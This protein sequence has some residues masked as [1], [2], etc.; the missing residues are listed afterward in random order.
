M[1]KVKYYVIASA[2][3]LAGIFAAYGD[4]SN[5]TRAIANV[6]V[7]EG[8]YSNDAGDP[9]GP[10]KYGITIWDVRKYLKPNATAADVKRLTREEAETIYREHYAKPIG[11][12]AMPKGLDYTVLDYSVNAGIG[13]AI[14]D[15]TKCKAMHKATIDLIKCVNAKR[16]AFQMGLPSR[17]DKFKKGWRRRIVSVEKISLNMAGVDKAIIGDVPA[18]A[19]RG[20]GK[21]YLT[22]PQ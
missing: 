3:A 8:G 17:F 16:M 2:I 15:L 9:G 12:D 18:V 6:F 19:A 4:A 1:K 14:P 22:P 5:Y 10:T 13:R 20:P 7:S 11:F 21:A